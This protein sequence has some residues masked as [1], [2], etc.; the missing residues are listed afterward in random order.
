MGECLVVSDI[1]CIF[2]M[3]PQTLVG[4]KLSGD[5]FVYVKNYSYLCI[6]A[7]KCG[8]GERGRQ[9]GVYSVPIVCDGYTTKIS[10]KKLPHNLCIK[11]DCRIFVLM[12]WC[13]GIGD[14]ILPSLTTLKVRVFL[15][16]T[17]INYHPLP[18]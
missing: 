8:G 3:V 15:L 16:R 12:L 2:V 4:D 11:K 1:I 6:D 9:V 7:L 17:N 5:I 10:I 14:S 18:L 13:V